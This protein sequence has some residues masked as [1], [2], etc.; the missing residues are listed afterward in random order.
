ML[1]RMSDEPNMQAL[2]VLHNTW[3]ICAT[4]VDKL[5]KWGQME[6][7]DPAI[8]ISAMFFTII[9]SLIIIY[10]GLKKRTFIG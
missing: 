3:V 9:F 4:S 5:P 7:A 6:F 1:Y 8:S 2:S 10:R